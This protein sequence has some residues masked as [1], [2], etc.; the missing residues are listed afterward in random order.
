[1]VWT[2]ASFSQGEI[3][4]R[5]A[6]VPQKAWLF[7]GTVASNLRFGNEGATEGDMLHALEVAQSTFVLDQPQGLDTPVAR[8]VRTF[9]AASASVWQSPVRS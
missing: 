9:R 2:C 5:I 8:A 1:M 3:R 6:Y 7:S 4:G